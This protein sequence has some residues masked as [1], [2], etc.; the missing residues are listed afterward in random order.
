MLELKKSKNV[1][2]DN[3]AWVS[4]LKNLYQCECR[5]QATQKMRG[6]ESVL[7]RIAQPTQIVC[8]VKVRR[9][10]ICRLKPARGTLDTRE[11]ITDET[12]TKPILITA[13]KH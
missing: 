1:N 3:F 11:L 5:I 2:A 8:C 10:G 6:K 13:R 4:Y 9:E 7:V 12:D